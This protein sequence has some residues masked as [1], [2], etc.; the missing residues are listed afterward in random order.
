MRDRRN[1]RVQIL[2][3]A[4]LLGVL[5]VLGLVVVGLAGPWAA[6]VYAVVVLAL[7]SVG[8]ARARAGQ[9]RA[10]AAAG[11]SCTCC[12][13]SHFDPVTVI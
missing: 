8:A 7:L 10:R 9:A 13:T 11:R 1:R 4:A 6:L 12:T 2:F 5:A 3:L